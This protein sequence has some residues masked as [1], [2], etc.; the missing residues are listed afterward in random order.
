MNSL[1]RSLLTLTMLFAGL[2]TMTAASQETR[3]PLET[4]AAVAQAATPPAA[5]TVGGQVRNATAAGSLPPALTIT[6]RRDDGTELA[7]TTMNADGAFT[8]T[9]IDIQPESSYFVTARYR[10]R[11]FFSPLVPGTAPALSIP[12]TLYE[13]TEDPS[14]ISIRRV[15]ARMVPMRFRDI[16]DGLEVTQTILFSNDSDRVY[17]TSR[18]ARE[19]AYASVIVPLPPG[20]VVIA[21]DNEER[22]VVAGEQF[23]VVDT[24]PVAPGDNH[25]VQVIYFLP[26]SDGAIIEQEVAF[27][28]NGSMRLEV[29]PESIAL[30]SEQLTLTGQETSDER[31]F[32]VYEGTFNLQPGEVIRYELSG[33]GLEALQPAQP[34]LDPAQILPITVLLLAVIAVLVIAY[35]VFKGSRSAR[36]LDALT[37]ELA[38]LEAQH[39]A[40]Q[41]NHDLYHQR[42][43]RLQAQID[44]LA[45]KE[46]A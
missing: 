39:N 18:Q 7:Q 16:G 22:Y 27:A 19:G 29:W 41:I 42:R 11:D 34:A 21:L 35:T 8:F 13:L 36:S 28:F 17:T 12:L 40:G 38:T 30:S 4:Q 37:R 9:N 45:K 10:D 31:A 25:P 14:V 43:R 24:L 1:R 23:T 3:A 6:L 26:Y 46:E 2:L 33:S 15:T 5:G 20:A 44:A 32:Q